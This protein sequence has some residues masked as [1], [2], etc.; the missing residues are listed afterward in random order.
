MSWLAVVNSVLGLTRDRGKLLAHATKPWRSAT[1][2]GTREQITLSFEGEEA[3][4]IGE[5]FLHTLTEHEFEIPGHVV[6]DV[7]T[8]W[9]HRAWQQ[10]RIDMQIELLLIDDAPEKVRA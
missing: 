10:S 6:A 8:C 1:F 3:I 2:A 7:T 9:V 5:A 4:V